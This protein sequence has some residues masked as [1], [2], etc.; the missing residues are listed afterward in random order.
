MT[1][2]Q[3]P[4]A[5]VT[6]QFVPT[7]AAVSIEDLP[8][9]C[10]GSAF[11]VY[12]KEVIGSSF[13]IID[14]DLLW[15]PIEK[16]VYDKSVIDQKAYDFYPVIVYSETPFGDIELEM[17]DGD[18][19][20]TGVTIGYDD[21]YK[22][23][24]TEQVAGSCQG[25]IP[26]YKQD[27]SAGDVRIEA[28]D[29]SVVIVDG[30]YVA[31]AR[32]RPGQ[33]VYVN[34]S[35]VWTFVGVVGSVGNDETRIK[36]ATPYSAPITTTG[37]GLV[38][39]AAS[40]SLIDIPDT[41]YD[42]NADFISSRTR[43]GDVV[44]ISTQTISTSIATPLEATIVAIIDKN[45]LRFNTTTITT[46]LEDSDFLKYKSFTA[47]PG[48]TLSLY[49]YWVERF[50]GFSQNYKMK[51]EGATPGDGV[52]V[53]QINETTL[54][55]L[56][57][58]TNKVLKINDLFIITAANQ[59]ELTDDRTVAAN[60]S[61]VKTIVDGGTLWTVTT[62]TPILR[63][64]GV[65]FSDNEFIA[66][67]E[68]K[69][70]SDI[71]VNFRSI[72]EE[73][74]G[75]VKR[76]TSIKDIA[77]AWTKDGEIG[78][79]NELAFMASIMFTLNGGKV[80]YGGNVDASAVN[81]STE[82]SSILED[83]KIKDVYSH[84]FGTTDAGV[85]AIAGPYCDNQAD[86]YEGHE[87]IA[88][89]CYDEDD[90]YSMGSDG[91]SVATTGIITI[92]GVMD[93]LSAGLTVND[94]AKIFDSSGGLVD[95]VTVTE[96]PDPGSPNA[97]QTDYSGSA[98]D[99]THSVQFL[100]GRKD[101][102]A[103]KIAAINYGN[104]RIATI[105]PGWFDANFSGNRYTL[106]PYYITAAI[107]AMDSAIGVAQSF[108]NKS[109]SIPGL[110]N[111]TLNTNHYFRKLQ[112]DDIGSGGVDIMIQDATVSQSIKS[113]HDLTSNMDAVIYRERSI[114]KQADVAAKTIRNAIAPYVGKY[115]LTDDLFQFIGQVISI[116][117]TKLLKE[118]ILR[119]LSM[120]SIGPDE[121]IADKIN[122][123]MEAQVFVAGNYYD[124]TLIVKS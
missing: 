40:V 65:A 122:I 82:Y 12:A 123:V 20:S 42:P 56:K 107:A 73:E 70:E 48:N 17:S 87:R 59:V 72:R 105:W 28:N 34:I 18:V 108:T 117:V 2:Y 41:I 115:N 54:T 30:G 83:F 52:P 4:H 9:V 77:D 100:S 25:I 43:V 75:V 113:R 3:G 86:P 106:P 95:T 23:P 88:V 5:A 71:K 46:G 68:P 112:L 81:L 116:V 19:A 80:F 120:V 11:D 58:D 21:A 98:L 111:I 63:V 1:T 85:N 32:V 67:W 102:Q 79:H 62:D 37:E 27:L 29:L 93:T 53:Q 60:I 31:T 104:R 90:I 118:G 7:P 97:V 74:T 89:L 64:D 47:T 13:G 14:N 91:C 24:N 15:D 22:V 119:N 110:S 114:T 96:T 39:G 92:D 121:V 35:S 78:I 45:T 84:A 16:V 51:L 36:L 38:I 50:V 10:I 99:G 55:Y 109:F 69:I 66:A 6:Q 49:T 103:L 44:H 101:D 76:I 26:Y 8:S 33:R 57:A 124:I 61:R 94:V